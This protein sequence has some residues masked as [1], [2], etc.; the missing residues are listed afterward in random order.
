VAETSSPTSAVIDPASRQ[1][2]WLRATSAGVLAAAVLVAVTALR[3]RGPSTAVHQTDIREGFA[4]WALVVFCAAVAV[5]AL[6]VRRAVLT[7]STWTRMTTLLLPAGLAG[8]AFF[9][10]TLGASHFAPELANA[11]SPLGTIGTLVGSI[12]IVLVIPF[13]LLLFAVA[14]AR[15]ASLSAVGRWAPTVAV[16]VAVVGGAVFAA[17]PERDESAVIAVLVV[18]FGG[19]WCALGIAVTATGG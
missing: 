15:A 12:T 9:F 1:V 11:E 18:A 8:A 16:V 3:E 14:L 17:A 6:A 13:G 7:S 5:L 10:L 2:G 4:P 19:L